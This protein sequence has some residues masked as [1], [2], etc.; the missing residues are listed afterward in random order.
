MAT[1]TLS[2]LL[3]TRHWRDTPTGIE[4]RY[5][6]ATGAEP[7]CV[8]LTGQE[9]VCFV[10]HGAS[11]PRGFTPRRVERDLQSLRD[12]H[13]LDT[14][15][16]GQQRS[17][18]DARQACRAT[19]VR[20]FESD[21]KPAD[22]Y[23]MERFVRCGIEVEGDVIQHHGYREVFAPRIKPGTIEQRLDVVSLDIETDVVDGTLLSIACTW[24]GDR[25][26]RLARVFIRGSTQ[27]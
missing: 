27:W 26:A 12:S 16:F 18:I 3:L 25:E 21:I 24:T 20:L 22:R 1:D 7:A 11:L 6:V 9:A 2:G 14:L 19:G 4:L 13:L 17:L 10:Q 8:V 5:W 15:Y 23:L